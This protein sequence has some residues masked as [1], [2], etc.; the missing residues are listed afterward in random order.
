MNAVLTLAARLLEDGI[1]MV[2]L[3]STADYWRIW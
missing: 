1:E 2:T 3:E